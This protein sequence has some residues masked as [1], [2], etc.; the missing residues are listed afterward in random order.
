MAAALA[1]L[2][3]L[4]SVHQPLATKESQVLT[5]TSPGTNRTAATPTPS[6]WASD[7]RLD[8]QASAP[9]GVSSH[10][11]VDARGAK[12]RSSPVNNATPKATR[13][14]LIAVMS[15]SILS[16]LGYSR[17]YPSRTQHRHK[18]QLGQSSDDT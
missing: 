15:G 9:D 4:L 17:H 14:H 18:P 6:S 1:D 10:S 8:E 2:E 3:E 7:F 11:E 12:A 5:A 13:V 16:T